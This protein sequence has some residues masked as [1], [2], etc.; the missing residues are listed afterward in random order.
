MSIEKLLSEDI[1]RTVFDLAYS[2]YENKSFPYSLYT[3]ICESVVKQ[4]PEVEDFYYNKWLEDLSVILKSGVKE[5]NYPEIARR[6]E[7]VFWKSFSDKKG[8]LKW[9]EEKIKELIVEK[10]KELSPELPIAKCSEL[11]EEISR[12]AKNL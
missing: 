8:F 1:K 7:E 11:I 6:I 9:K 12:L 10:A 3:Y 2:A 4:V 5:E